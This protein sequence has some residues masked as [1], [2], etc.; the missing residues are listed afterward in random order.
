MTISSID[1]FPGDMLR[2]IFSFVPLTDAWNCE[3]VCKTWQAL[4]RD[5]SR[6][7][8]ELTKRNI[9]RV[10]GTTPK[11]QLTAFFRKLCYRYL[12]LDRLF[13]SEVKTGL[14]IDI[15]A[16]LEPRIPDLI[17]TLITNSREHQLAED[18]IISFL[19]W[20]GR[21]D[22]SLEPSLWGRCTPAIKMEDLLNSSFDDN[23]RELLRHR[24]EISCCPPT[25]MLALIQKMD[26]K[27]MSQQLWNRIL[28]KLFDNQQFINNSS[29]SRTS[30][31]QIIACAP[32]PLKTVL[33]I[34]EQNLPRQKF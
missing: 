9:T 2:E 22:S 29:T 27:K 3:R 10:T 1:G 32:F 8:R 6:W 16:H 12:S 19:R 23:F 13:P 4:I 15:V 25:I 34:L 33:N 18:G 31:M 7:G 5:D 17:K 14:F 30:F 26:P 21:L 28:S 24:M 11:S 20:G